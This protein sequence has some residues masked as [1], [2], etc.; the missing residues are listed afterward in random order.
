MSS[1][2][3]VQVVSQSGNTPKTTIDLRIYIGNDT[4]RD[5][6]EALDNAEAELRTKLRAKF[7]EL[8][9]WDD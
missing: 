8:R 5:T 1:R 4:Y 6:L 7:G 2:P 9:G 3:N